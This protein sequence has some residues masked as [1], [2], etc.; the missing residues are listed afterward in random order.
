MDPDKTLNHRKFSAEYAKNGKAKCKKCRL[1]IQ[2][3]ELRIGKSVPYKEHYIV[4]FFH[5]HC[6]FESFKNARFATNVIQHEDDI[7]GMNK[8]CEADH[9]HI[10]DLIITTNATR[11]KLFTEAGQQSKKQVFTTGQA[12]RANL[13]PS[14]VPSFKVLY[15]NADVLTTVKMSE[16]HNRIAVEKP[17]IIAITEVKPKNQTHTRSVLDY[18]IPDFTPHPVNIETVKGRGMI[19]YTHRSI[20]KS[21]AKIEAKIDFEKVCLLEIRL[22]KGY[23][24]IWVFL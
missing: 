11:T 6:I 10:T 3:N 1:K 22:Q 19:V 8:L 14:S 24:G 15:T 16:L 12:R 7:E 4:Q 17:L 13:K 2:K 9:C 20:E 23:I 21:V 5:P 18:E